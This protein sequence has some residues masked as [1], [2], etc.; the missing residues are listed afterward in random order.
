MSK[1][2]YVKIEGVTNFENGIFEFDFMNQRRGRN[3]DGELFEIF[4]GAY[5][6]NV[7]SLVGIN[8]SGKTTAAKLLYWATELL[9]TSS[10]QINSL[11]LLNI[12]DLIS[13]KAHISVI[14]FSKKT[15]TIFRYSASIGRD[16]KGD[17]AIITDQIDYRLDMGK[18]SR[19]NILE[20]DN[21]A[22][23]TRA[24]ITKM[25]AQTPKEKYIAEQFALRSDEAIIRYTQFFNA[26]DVNLYSPDKYVRKTRFENVSPHILE[27]LDKA[28][29]YISKPDS[30]SR[31]PDGAYELKF[32]N[33][34]TIKTNRWGLE[35]KLSTGTVRWIT[36]FDLAIRSLEKGSYLII[37][38]LELSLHKA[39]AVDLMRLFSS[40]MTNPR[41]ATLIFST[42]YIEL[43]D[44]IKRDDSIYVTSKNTEGF[45][46]ITNLSHLMAR[47][48]LS[49]SDYFLKNFTREQTAPSRE[50]YNKIVGE[51]IKRVS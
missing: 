11:H 14:A 37:D 21:Y 45:S 1:I 50:I 13:E 10:L 42:H 46:R 24:D 31:T 25:I 30:E 23:I 2:L 47:N 35:D 44:S 26:I 3:N 33:R 29:D 12:T 9:A 5:T 32:K 34:A 15:K 6:H 22:T 39:L 7:I 20:F 28:I 18:I 27:Y 51:V 16:A 17:F 49:K 40:K 8:S 4:T 41:G 19:K 36:L 43:L 38:E 48:D